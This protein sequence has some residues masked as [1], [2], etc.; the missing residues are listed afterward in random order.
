VLHISEEA[1]ERYVMRSLPDSEV[2]SL[3]VHLFLCSDCRDR[4]VAVL[5]AASMGAAVGKQ[6]WQVVRQLRTDYE[7]YGN[8]KTRRI[9]LLLWLP[10][11]HQT[12]WRS[13]ERLGRVL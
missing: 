4:L 13:W 6:L 8:V 2:E 1:L 9:R 3:E 10:P 7:P 5:N 12:R 11:L